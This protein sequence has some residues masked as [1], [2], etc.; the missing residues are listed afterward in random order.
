M[1]PENLNNEFKGFG[2]FNDIEDAEL[3]ARNRAVVLSNMAEDYTNTS[4]RISV[5]GAAL[6]L[7]Y[8]NQLPAS[9]RNIVKE[10]FAS[11]MIQKGFLLAP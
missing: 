6:I 1:T 10:K 11:T 4:R 3:R 9:E 7:G 5:K 2:L 8:F